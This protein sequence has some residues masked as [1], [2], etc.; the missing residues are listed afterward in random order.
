[1]RW[2]DRSAFLFCKLVYDIK[3][4]VADAIA[5]F[6]S[7]DVQMVTMTVVNNDRLHIL[8]F[9]TGPFD[10]VRNLGFLAVH[11]YAYA[12]DLG[13]EPYQAEYRGYQNYE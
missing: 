13:G 4:A 5:F 11:E 9:V 8:L 2:C 1:M 12:V 10:Q 6:M 7:V 3:K